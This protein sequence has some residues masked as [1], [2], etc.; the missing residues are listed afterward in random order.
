MPYNQQIYDDLLMCNID[1]ESKA[2]IEKDNIYSASCSA[3]LQ[4]YN[5]GYRHFNTTDSSLHSNYNMPYRNKSLLGLSKSY[6]DAL[7]DYRIIFIRMQQLLYDYQV[8]KSLVNSNTISHN[9]LALLDS[10]SEE[11]NACITQIQIFDNQIS[12]LYEVDLLKRKIY[13]YKTLY[14]IIEQKYINFNTLF[15]SM[16]QQHQSALEA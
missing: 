9:T 3:I 13:I 16:Q 10:L 4:Q 2:N 6:N 14:R 11:I 5:S 8:L 7:S 1:K 15:L 12:I